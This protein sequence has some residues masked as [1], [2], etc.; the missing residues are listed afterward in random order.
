MRPSGRLPVSGGE[1]ANRSTGA[2]TLFKT[3]E[4]IDRWGS[5]NPAMVSAS[6]DP[7]AP[8]STACD[9]RVF[10]SD[11]SGE[12]RSS[13]LMLGKALEVQTAAEE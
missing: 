4:R 13:P 1:R 5:A 9:G 3:F 2:V 11:D 12:T 8:A 10:R 7:R 6:V